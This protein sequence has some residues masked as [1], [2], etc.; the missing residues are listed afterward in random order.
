MPLHVIFLLDRAA[1]DGQ[2]SGR[3]YVG[4]PLPGVLL[5]RGETLSGGF[6]SFVSNL[7]CPA[8]PQLEDG[9][10]YI[11]VNA[12]SIQDT[13]NGLM[14]DDTKAKTIA[15]QGIEWYTKHLRAQDVKVRPQAL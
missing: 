8:P 15:A 10:H 4:Q 1:D 3:A 13:V 14:A 6:V 2:R 7:A 9:V 12:G 11:K 5:Q